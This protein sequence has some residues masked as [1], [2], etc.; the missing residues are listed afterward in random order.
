MPTTILSSK[1]QIIIPKPLRE[2]HRWEPGQRFDVIETGEGILL[3]PVA[4][5][6]ATSIADVA[7]CLPFK[8]KAK[9]LAEME[10]AIARGVKETFRD[11]D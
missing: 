10:E 11:S 6:S 9:T 4:P 3:K 7:G 5:F 2:T 8:G 1:G